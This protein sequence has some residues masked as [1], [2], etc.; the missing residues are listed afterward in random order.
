MTTVLLVGIFTV[1]YILNATELIQRV[2]AAT[3]GVAASHPDA[4]APAADDAESSPAATQHSRHL[5][6]GRQV[7]VT[8]AHSTLHV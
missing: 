1:A 3:G 6:G 8:D 5:P 4:A 2:Q 7:V